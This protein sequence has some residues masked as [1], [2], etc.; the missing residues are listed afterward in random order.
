[1]NVHKE[2]AVHIVVITA[3]GMGITIYKLKTPHCPK[4]GI[5]TKTY[6]YPRAMFYVHQLIE[7]GGC[8]KTDTNGRILYVKELAAAVVRIVQ[9]KEF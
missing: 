7:H 5:R 3:F 8:A 1:M 2:T 9:T 4:N 6:H